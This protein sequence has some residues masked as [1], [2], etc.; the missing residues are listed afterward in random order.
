MKLPRTGQEYAHW[1]VTGGPED[2]T[3]QVK[4]F[5]PDGS[6]TGWLNAEAVTVSSIRKLV[7]GPSKTSP[8]A[9]A[10]VLPLGENGV[11]IRLADA[12]EDV[13]RQGGYIE[14]N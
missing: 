10:T 2:G 14:V 1:N 12:P 13:I 11:L 7:A 3:Y 6:D 4:F 8:D 9:S 5:K